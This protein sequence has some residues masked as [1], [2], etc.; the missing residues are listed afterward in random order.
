MYCIIYYNTKLLLESF[1]FTEDMLKAQVKP[2][3]NCI[4]NYQL[5]G[6]GSNL[7]SVSAEN[8]ILTL[9]P[10]T[11]A[12]FSRKG[13]KANGLRY[14]CE[15]FTERFLSGGAAV[16]A[17]NPEDCGTVESL[18]VPDNPVFSRLFRTLSVKLCYGITA[19]FTPFSTV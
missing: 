14:K 18:P 6:L 2:F 19:N 15:G 17:Y 8:L 16:V 11:N 7:V 9:L 5:E 13:L 12:M 4:W 10:R 1:P 3:A